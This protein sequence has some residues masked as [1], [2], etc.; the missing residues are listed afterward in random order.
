VVVIVRL[1]RYKAQFNT[2]LSSS[3]TNLNQSRFI[4]LFLLA[5]TLLL[6]FLP[7]QTYI[8]YLNLA[9]PL[10][11]YSWKLVH[12]PYWGSIIKVPTGGAVLFDRWIRVACGFLIFIFFGL[13]KDAITMYRTWLLKLGL[14]K[15]FPNLPH[16]H[17]R[18]ASA[19][20]TGN[21]SKL[22][23]LSSKARSMFR[24]GSQATASTLTDYST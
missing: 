14:G 7:L 21:S 20:E 3:N 22:Y 4:R 12:G 16:A 1:Y 24:K 6:I 2:I 8:L 17:L 15:I 10:H 11:A 13:G 5:L 23:L 9:F 19:T 18:M